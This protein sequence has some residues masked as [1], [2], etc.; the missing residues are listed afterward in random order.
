MSTAAFPNFK[1]TNIFKTTTVTISVPSAI[2]GIEALDGA[3]DG[4]VY[5]VAGQYVQNGTKGLK[6]GT[7]IVRSGAKAVKILVK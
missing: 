1:G 4:K 2:N 3:L 6:S 5:N 7:Y